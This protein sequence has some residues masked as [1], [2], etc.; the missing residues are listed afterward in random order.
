MIERDDAVRIVEEELARGHQAWAAAGVEQFPRSVVVRVVEHELAWK[1]YVQSEEYER[2]RNLPAMLVGHGPYL[3][4]RAD[5]G[6]HSIG[7]LSA[8][9]GA[10]EDDYR[11]RIRGLPVRTPVD[12]LHDQLRTAAEATGGRMAAVRAL[13][14]KVTGLSPA[15]ALAY[16]SGLL[17]GEVPPQ[18]LA[19]ARQD[20]VKPLD[21][22]YAVRTFGIDADF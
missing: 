20:L 19:I 9:N 3:V 1:V 7:V 6:L 10:W 12:D 13:R 4:D 17:A 8:I 16:V 2:T 18:L 14:R 11:S 15:H 22:V 5:G 21:R